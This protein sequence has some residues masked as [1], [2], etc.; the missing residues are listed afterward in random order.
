MLLPG[1]DIP[2]RTVTHISATLFQLDGPW[3]V[4]VTCTNC[5][6]EIYVTSIAAKPLQKIIPDLA[7][8]MTASIRPPR[9]VTLGVTYTFD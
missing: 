6:N 1:T 2:D 8:D 5:F 3:S 7:T 9:L 4:G